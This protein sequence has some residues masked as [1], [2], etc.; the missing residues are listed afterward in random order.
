M[1]TYITITDPE[2]DPDA[3]LTSELAKK[4]R[5]NPLAM[6]E[7]DATAVAAGITLKDAALDTGA[8][9]AA[10]ITWVGARLASFG[11]GTVGSYAFLLREVAGQLLQGNTEAGSNL[12][13][14][15]AFGSNDAPVQTPSGTWRLMGKIDVDPQDR[16]S[17]W[18][19]I[20]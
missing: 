15:N 14:S 20:S 1:T 9:T 10:G 11:V 16:T 2:T 5:D 12:R 4:W 19:R 6:F 17:L 7:G 3:P 13:Y 18:L 8:P